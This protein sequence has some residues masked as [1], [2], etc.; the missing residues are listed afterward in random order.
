MQGA[1]GVL[2]AHPEEKAILEGH[3]DG[4]GSVEYNIGLSKRRCEAALDFLVREEKI[5]VE[6]LV[7]RWYGKSRPV[8]DNR[9]TQG[10][11]LNRRVELKTDFGVKVPVGP[12]DWFRGAPFVVLNDLPIAVDA[13]GRFET[14]V[15]ADSGTL[16]VRMGDSLGRLLATSIPVPELKLAQPAGVQLVRYGTASGAVRVDASGA[17]FCTV[18][19]E[20]DPGNALE[21]E[22]SPV[23]LDARGHFSLELPLRPG[24]QVIGMLLTGAG[25]SKLMNL[26]VQATVQ[27]PVPAPVPGG[28]KP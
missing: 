17:A 5:P 15:P 4:I 7:R 25:C 26:S 11:R 24:E 3:T 18:T 14:A 16:K 2:R 21:L 20:T 22:G 13:L 27:G 1:A 6:R 23:A 28:Q 10:R 8:A 12:T 9:S 19:G